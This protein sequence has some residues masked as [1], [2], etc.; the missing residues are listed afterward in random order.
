MMRQAVDRLGLDLGGAAVLTEAASGAYIVT[1][2]IAAMAGARVWAV[3]RDS[4]HGSAAEVTRK[5]LAVARAAGC[6][7]QIS[8]VPQA[9]AAIVGD[10]DIVTNSGHL[11]PIDRKIVGWMKP[12]A[13]IPLMYEAWELRSDDVDLEACRQRGIPTAGTNEEHPL[14]GVFDDL[15]RLVVRQLL[16][17]GVRTA[18]SHVLL[19]CDN[20]FAPYI[21]RALRRCEASVVRDGGDGHACWT[22]EGPFDAVVLA[23]TP[24]RR[25]LVGGDAAAVVRANTLRHACP[26]GPLVQ[27]WG[28]IDR[29]ALDVAGVR[30]HPAE[31]PAKG[32]MG[33]L[34]S[35]LGP[36][37]VVRLQAAGLKVGEIM[38]REMAAGDPQAAVDAATRSGYASLTSPGRG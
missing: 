19:L 9:S 1:P 17:C 22:Q 8:V 37:P 32:H 34:L 4:R 29:A 38:W 35:S 30:Y 16:E 5:T 25:D 7:D 24:R 13:V 18:H 15:G 23:M 6:A 28:D 36:M 27:I 21:E 3:T 12:T 26:R 10:A 31:P 11:R 33:A 2:L 14:V 20:R